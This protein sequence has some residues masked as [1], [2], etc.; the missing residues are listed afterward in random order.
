MASVELSNRTPRTDWLIFTE[1]WDDDLRGGNPLAF[2]AYEGTEAGDRA[3]TTGEALM[4]GQRVAAIEFDFSANGGTMGAVTGER[5]VRAFDR[6]ATRRLPV[7]AI[8]ASGGARLQEGMVALVQMARTV[9]ARARLARAGS[10]LIVVFDSPTTGG[11]YASWSSLADIRAAVRGATIGFGGPRVVELVTGRRPGPDSHTAESAW[12]AGLVDA[13][14][15]AD[16]VGS[17]VA[18]ALG[19]QSEPLQLPGDRPSLFVDELPVPPVDAYSLVCGTRCP[20]RASGLEWAAAL[21]TSWCELHGA[22]AVFRAGI[23]VVGGIRCVI[24]AMDRHAL[25]D[26]AARPMPADFRLAQRA[27]AL[28]GSLGLP[29]LTLIDTPGAEPGSAAEADG[30]ASEIAR[31]LLGMAQLNTPSVALCVGEGGSGGAVALAHA[32]RF[33]MVEDSVFSVIGPEAAALILARDKNR[34][35][36]MSTAL[37]LTAPDLLEL[38]IVDALVPVPNADTINQIRAVVKDALS[39]ATFGDRERRTDQATQRWLRAP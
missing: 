37:K 16:G 24:V 18:L 39:S 31:T 26:A 5:I 13:V 38:G 12:K 29:L 17:W 32:D 30:I 19:T 4:S 35:A 6:A 20:K 1:L 8:T 15:E 10:P 23:A 7:V 21:S 14:L 2:P 36:E 9:S 22:S 3:V 25:G 11:V 28:A 34:A 33:L 27:I